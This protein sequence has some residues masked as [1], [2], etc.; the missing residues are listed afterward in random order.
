[1]P[2]RTPMCGNTFGDGEEMPCNAANPVSPVADYDVIVIGAGPGGAESARTAV[3]AGLRTL[4]LEEHPTVGVP[5]HCTG[6]LSFHAFDELEIP[7]TLAHTAVSAAVLYSPSGVAVRVRRS[8]VD[9]YA[10]DRIVFDRWVAQRAQEAG[11]ELVTGVRVTEAARVNGS[12]AVRGARASRDRRGGIGPAP[13]RDVG[14]RDS[15]AA[16]VRPAVPNP[17]HRRRGTGHARD[18]LWRR[19]RAGLFRVA[20]AGGKR[21]EPRWARRGSS[22]DAAPAGVVP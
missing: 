18:V 17:R 13:A 7:R 4:L 11:A 3:R 5:S 8:T 6:K 16:R 19:R 12:V 2:S 20:D 1:M 9:S 15:P 10:V 14:R 22:T 21:H